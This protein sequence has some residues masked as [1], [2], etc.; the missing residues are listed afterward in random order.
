MFM[1]RD[2]GEDVIPEHPDLKW[3][4]STL[5]DRVKMNQLQNLLHDALIATGHVENCAIVRRKDIS[6]RAS[7][8]GFTL[9][10]DEMQKLIDAFKD[11]PRTRQEGLYFH[12]KLYKCVRAD[13]NSIYAKCDKVGMVLVKTATLVIM[14]TYSDNMYSS[15][16]VEAIEK[17]A[18]YF[19]E[20]SK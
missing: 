20:K 7:S 11:P 2:K 14:G 4:D 13:K 9:S 19:I 15:V 18:S 12:D 8:A 16:C 5:P 1:E 10:G 6:L 3:L 17:L